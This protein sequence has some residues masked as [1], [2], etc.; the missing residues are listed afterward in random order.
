M[1]GKLVSSLHEDFDPGKRKDEYR[2][3]VLD[4]IKRLAAGKK[5]RPPK[6]KPPEEAPDLMA[7]L[8]ASLS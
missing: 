8:K 4:M 6:D 1:A 5:P 3:T 7:A 2:E